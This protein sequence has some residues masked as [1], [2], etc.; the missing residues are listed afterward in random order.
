MRVHSFKTEIYRSMPTEAM[1][2]NIK[3]VDTLSRLLKLFKLERYQPILQNMSD[4][5][6]LN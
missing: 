6:I 3:T 5:V 2:W 4:L 1:H